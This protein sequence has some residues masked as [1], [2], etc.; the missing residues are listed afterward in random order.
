MSLYGTGRQQLF[1]E[2]MDK[3]IKEILGTYKIMKELNSTGVLTDEQLR[4]EKVKLFDRFIPLCETCDK[5]IAP[6]VN[7]S[8]DWS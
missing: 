7:P 3:M 1:E 8:S 4:N 6:Y 2:K 5:Y